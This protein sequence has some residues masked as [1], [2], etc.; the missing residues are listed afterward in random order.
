MAKP[1]G[2]SCDDGNKCTQTD[3]CQAGACLGSNPVVCTASDGCHVA[4]TCVPGTG[5]CSAETNAP[6]N[7]GCNDGN[8]CT[9]SDKCTSGS[10]SGTLDPTGVCGSNT[11]CTNN[12][13]TASC[14]C[15]AKYGDCNSGS[16]CETPLNT[17]ENCGRC[18]HDCHLANTADPYCLGGSVCSFQYC[19]PGYY[20]CNDN[21]PDG[22]ESTVKCSIGEGTCRSGSDCISGICDYSRY[23]SCSSGYYDCNG[24]E[25]CSSYGQC[26][27]GQHCHHNGDCV[28]WKCLNGI[29]Q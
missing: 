2:T 28:S 5:E 20:N 3:T 1:N 12:G 16:G 6:D 8:G 15:Q 29:C 24:D 14:S 23:C 26:S 7:I 4:G 18:G 27:T 9:D 22:C 13:G 19:N 11:I 21:V 10:C 25:S 17:L